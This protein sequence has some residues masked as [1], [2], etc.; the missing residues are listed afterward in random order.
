MIDLTM[1]ELILWMITVPMLIV[2]FYS[3]FAAM[4]R[5]AAIRAARRSIVTC[6]LCGHL[7]Q[8]CSR[9]SD[10]IC[11]ECGRANERGRSRRLG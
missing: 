6:R 8:D 4:K 5:R 2:G 11:P 9:D 1:E 3:V 10:P 7:Y